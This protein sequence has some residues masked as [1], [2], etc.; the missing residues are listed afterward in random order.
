[1]VVMYS[2]VRKAAKE[3]DIGVRSPVLARP[4]DFDL[5]RKGV[6]RPSLLDGLVELRTESLT[7]GCC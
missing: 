7:S 6:Q 4:N 1:M 2:L 5:E 3:R